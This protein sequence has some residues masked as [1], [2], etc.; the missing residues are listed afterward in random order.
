MTHNSS[1][2]SYHTLFINTHRIDNVDITVAEL[3]REGS[4]DCIAQ[5]IKRGDENPSVRLI[6]WYH[7][8]LELEATTRGVQKIRYMFNM[9]AK[10]PQS[11]VLDTTLTSQTS[12]GNEEWKRRN[13]RPLETPESVVGRLERR[14]A[15]LSVVERQQLWQ[16]KKEASLNTMRQQEQMK[17][18]RERKMSAPDLTKSRKS[19]MGRQLGQK[20]AAGDDENIRNHAG[21]ANKRM[22]TEKKNTGS[23]PKPLVTRRQTVR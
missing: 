22:K 3:K 13:G 10:E 18:T 21:G 7:A 14:K 16:A 5:Q 23:A 11:F 8:M 12:T 17:A 20:R 15:T 19:F 4:L 2:S 1:P 9:H 6:S